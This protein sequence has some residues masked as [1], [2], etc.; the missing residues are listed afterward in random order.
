MEIK[1]VSEDF[2]KKPI[3]KIKNNCLKKVAE[4]KAVSNVIGLVYVGLPL[5]PYLM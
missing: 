2:F 4:K 5:N 1:H 3:K